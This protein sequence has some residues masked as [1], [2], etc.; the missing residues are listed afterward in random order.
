MG[1]WLCRETSACPAFPDVCHISRVLLLPS[2]P[3]LRGS[4]AT[5]NCLVLTVYLDSTPA[6]ANHSTSFANLL[7]VYEGQGS[8]GETE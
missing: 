2:N 4:W 7:Q 8:R 1:F 5:I 6:S 3:K